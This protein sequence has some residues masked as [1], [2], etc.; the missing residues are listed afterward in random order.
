MTTKRSEEYFSFT[1]S[2]RQ[3]QKTEQT[4]QRLLRFDGLLMKFN[5]HFSLVYFNGLKKA[6]LASGPP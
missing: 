4:L 3:R 2:I 1:N 5:S 6:I